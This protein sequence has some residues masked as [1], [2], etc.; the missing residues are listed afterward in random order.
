[1]SEYQ[2]SLLHIPEPYTVVRAFLYYLYTD[3]IAPSPG[4][5]PSLTS[6]C[7]SLTAVAGMLV[8]A[9][10]Y[11]MPKLRL[12]CVNRLAREIDVENAAVIWESSGRTDEEWLR[13]RAAR[14]CMGNWGRVVRTEGFKNLPRGSLMELCEVVDTEGRV[15][16]GDELDEGGFGA[17]IRVGRERGSVGADEDGTEG[18]EMSI[19]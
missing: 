14:F 15:I 18:E 1:M 7:P 10:L 3:S 19:D 16:G 8:M 2:Q 6:G 9:N 13:G 11:D 5:N 4:N 12:L 17:N